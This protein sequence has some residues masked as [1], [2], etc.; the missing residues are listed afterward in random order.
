MVTRRI[1]VNALPFL[2]SRPWGI[3][4]FLL[5]PV[6]MDVK[7]VAVLLLPTLGPNRVDRYE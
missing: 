3:V 6:P 7:P 4:A 1:L 5:M 2:E